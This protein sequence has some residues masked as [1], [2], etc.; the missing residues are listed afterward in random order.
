[1]AARYRCMA[2]IS[3][4]LSARCHVTS[5]SKPNA[6]V[7]VPTAGLAV[8]LTHMLVGYTRLAGTAAVEVTPLVMTCAPEGLAIDVHWYSQKNALSAA[9]APP[10]FA[11]TYVTNQ[12]LLKTRPAK[13]A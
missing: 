11:C 3:V 7:E 10:K 5:S 12:P 6:L 4:A 8:G 1:M 2:A 13:P 9:V